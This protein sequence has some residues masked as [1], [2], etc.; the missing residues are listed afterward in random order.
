M[1]PV[2][3]SM[4]MILSRLL[5][6]SQA[7][8]SLTW[9]TDSS[10]RWRSAHFLRRS[11]LSHSREK[12]EA[13]KR[14]ITSPSPRLRETS[15]SLSAK[16]WAT[17]SGKDGAGRP[18]SGPPVADRRYGRPGGAWAGGPRLRLGRW[19]DEGLRAG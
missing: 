19:R 8:W 16:V 10:V 17:L 18:P 6:T 11:G 7:S 4:G 14:R 2:S 1:V 12:N 15:L 5:A 3:A 9:R 13:L